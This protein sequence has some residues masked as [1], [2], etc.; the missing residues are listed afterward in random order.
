MQISEYPVVQHLFKSVHPITIIACT[1]YDSIKYCCLFIRDIL[2]A[3]LA[4]NW[5]YYICL[6]LP[7]LSKNQF[8]WNKKRTDIQLRRMV[9]FL[10]C[11]ALIHLRPFYWLLLQ[12]RSLTLWDRLTGHFVARQSFRPRGRW[13][14]AF[15][16]ILCMFRHS[17]RNSH[18]FEWHSSMLMWAAL[19]AAC[20][21]LR[22]TAPNATKI[23]HTL[24]VNR[25]KWML[26]HCFQCRKY[27]KLVAVTILLSLSCFSNRVCHLSARPLI[28][29]RP[30]SLTATSAIFVGVATKRSDR[31]GSRTSL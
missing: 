31:C 30:T 12:N 25:M 13:E 23:R 17:N 24:C 27:V 28:Q 3:Y 15:C 20:N 8:K 29:R 16:A 19:W 21:L 10:S 18:S 1:V 9:F 11:L 2:F 26:S 14:R 5:V 7:W 22:A 6:F 4:N